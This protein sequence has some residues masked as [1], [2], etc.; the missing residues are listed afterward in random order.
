MDQFYLSSIQFGELEVSTYTVVF[1]LVLTL[2]I[3]IAVGLSS[4]K[5]VQSAVDK[6]KEED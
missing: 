3:F 6:N 2:F 5:L 4:L 1:L